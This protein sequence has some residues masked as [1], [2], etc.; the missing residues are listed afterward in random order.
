L[1]FVKTSDPG[2]TDKIIFEMPAVSR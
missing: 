2:N 1:G